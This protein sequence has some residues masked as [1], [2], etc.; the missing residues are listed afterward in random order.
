MTGKSAIQWTDLT[1]N[2][3]SGCTRVTEGCRNCYAFTLHT[4]RHEAY[5]R[6]GGIYPK[7]GQRMPEQY[8]RPFSE[9]QLIDHRLSDP[10]KEKK[11]RHIFV[12]S[13]S[14]LF[15][16][17]V[18]D[19][20]IYKVF[21]VMHRAHWHT[22]QILTK[23]AGRL[24]RLGEQLQ[25]ASNIWI[26]VS[27]EKDDLTPR[28]DALRE[29]P[30]FVKF[31]SCE[32]LL[33]ALPSLNLSGIHQVI[34]G[35]ESGS[36]ARVFDPDWARDIRDRCAENNVAFFMKQMGTYWSKT[37]HSADRHGGLIHEWP[38]DLQIQEFPMVEVRNV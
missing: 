21:D 27:I 11:P 35:G 2:P 16:S 25:W 7:N 20:Y 30:A 17:A 24:R 36:D 12:N 19:A 1:W 38:D 22:F 6:Y 13:M 18:P 3:L 29:V 5:Q 23:R 9:I 31:L 37:H 34:V 26:G 14:D 32:P 4:M 8:S 15:H 28:V 33:E 10:L